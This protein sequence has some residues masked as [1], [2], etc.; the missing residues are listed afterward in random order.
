MRDKRGQFYLVA[1][2]IIV[3]VIIGIF[4]ITNFAKQ[5]NADKE[6]NFLEK[7]LNIEIEKNFEY[8]SQNDLSQSEIR[9]LWINFSSIQTLDMGE[10]KNILFLFGNST[11]T[12][13]TGLRLDDSYDLLINTGNGFENITISP[14]EFQESFDITEDNMTIREDTSDYVFELE[15][16]QHFYYIISKENKG[17]RTIIKG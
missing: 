15:K 3:A 10:N 17:E 14:G 12:I 7:K 1:A 2:M 16:G 5:T 4:G 11:K 9:T 8:I 13:A 6:L